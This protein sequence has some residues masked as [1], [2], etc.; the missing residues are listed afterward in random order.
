MAAAGGDAISSRTQA[1]IDAM[2]TPPSAA[3]KQ[4][5][6]TYIEGL[7]DEGVWAVLDCL[8]ICANFSEE[9]AL[10][11]VVDP[12]TADLVKISSPTFTTDVGWLG[13]AS[14]TH[15]LYNNV[16][17]NTYTH[18][19]QDDAHIACYNSAEY[20]A[21]NRAVS[22]GGSGANFA[23]ILPR[24]SGSAQGYI[25]IGL[26]GP[27]SAAVASAIGYYVG[28]RNS[29]SDQEIWKDGSLVTENT[30]ASAMPTTS[31]YL[32]GYAGAANASQI[33]LAHVGGKL[34]SSQIAAIDTLWDSYL[35]NI[36]AE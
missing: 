14:G 29:S 8:Y 17:M 20:N 35:T 18:F 1:Y 25:N 2:T 28:N 32:C 36:A 26:T 3:R 27:V 33:G 13:I 6:N 9:A 23:A 5:L 24:Y 11:N 19:A 4:N 30:Q 31:F 7:Y 34:T 10:I 16:A 12:G 21:A 22:S 15:H